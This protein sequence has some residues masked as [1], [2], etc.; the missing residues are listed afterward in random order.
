MDFSPSEEQEMLA[1]TVAKFVARNYDAGKRRA[2]SESTLGFKEE[3]WALLGELGLLGLLLPE[4]VGG[5][6]G[7][8]T[9]AMIVMIELGRGRVLEPYVSS[10]LVCASLVRQLAGTGRHT[11]L[12][13]DVASGKRR[14]ALAAIEPHTRYDLLDIR[15]TAIAE[16][17]SFRI[18][19]SKSVV[20]DGPSADFFLITAT[21][22]GGEGITMFVLPRG[23]A[24]VE[25][26][27]FTTIDGGRCADLVLH[28]VVL[29][30]ADMLGPVSGASESLRAAVDLGI[31]ALCAE[32]VGAM[33]ELCR[34]T[35]DYLRTRKQ[36]KQPLAS[37][38]AL[39]HR[40]ADMMIAVEQC[41]SAAYI[42]AAGV[43]GSDT[44]ERERSV[45]AAK[46]LVGKAARLVGQSAVQL[47]GGIGMTDELPVGDYFKRL[48][49]IDLTWG[50]S[51]YQLS[52][53]SALM[54][55]PSTSNSQGA[56]TWT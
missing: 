17:G 2:L 55:G 6:G 24:G 37:F 18:S 9:D 23:H 31:A 46:Y 15:T 1:D 5:M 7:S 3:N 13:A 42:A 40:Y 19:G 29:G 35:A 33:E 16:A 39:Q 32:A 27:A 48:S 20:L 11:G 10:A 51:D 41:R 4:E 43:A 28:D 56:N 38:Q 8:P 36:F 44:P 53:F 34:M 25:L 54:A 30:A 12:L 22:D 14:L 47:H 52:R 26:R 21:V 50:D 45:A 49:C